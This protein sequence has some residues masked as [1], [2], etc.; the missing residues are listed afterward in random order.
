MYCGARYPD[1]D[2]HGPG[3]LLTDDGLLRD[4]RIAHAAAQKDVRE[5]AQVEAVRAVRAQEHDGRVDA[6]TRRGRS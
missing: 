6:S 5:E 4:G 2:E 3:A 1:G